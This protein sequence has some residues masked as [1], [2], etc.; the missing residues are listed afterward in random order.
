[1]RGRRVGL[2]SIF[3]SQLDRGSLSQREEP[4]EVPWPNTLVL[5]MGSWLQSGEVVVAQPISHRTGS[6][7]RPINIC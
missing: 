6:G 1:M 2:C 4:S 3:W 7:G 5:W